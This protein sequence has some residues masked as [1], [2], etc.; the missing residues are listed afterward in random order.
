MWKD[1]KELMTRDGR[2]LLEA[3]HNQGY[4][5]VTAVFYNHRRKQWMANVPGTFS[6][7]IG[8]SKS[9]ALDNI[10]NERLKIRK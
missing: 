10:K 2:K 4:S 1:G 9:E 8:H 7:Y 6:D 3:L 5:K